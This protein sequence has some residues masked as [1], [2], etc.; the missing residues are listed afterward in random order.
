MPIAAAPVAPIAAHGLLLLLLQV[1]LLLLLALLLGRLAARFGMPAIVGELC[2]GVIAGPS[3]LAHV[4]PDFYE[5]LLPNDP[6]QFHLLDAVGQVGVMLLVGITGL[7]LDLSLLRRRAASAARV[8]IGGVV[9]PLGLG[10]LIGLVLPDSLVPDGTERS[11]FA[12]FLGVAMAVSAIPVLAKTLI[13][14]RMLHRNIGQLTLCAVVIDDVIGWLLLAVVSAM[15][16]TGLRAG[17]LGLSLAYLALTIVAAFLLRP[18]VR[19][20]LRRSS[21]LD[22]VNNR[23]GVGGQAATVTLTVVLILLAAAA[24]QAMKLEA[25]FGAFVCGMVINSCNVVQ[26]AQIAPLRNVVL[27][28]LAPVFFA[29]AGLRMDLTLLGDLTVLLTGFAV[30]ACAVVGKFVGAY[31]GAR[32]SRLTR[33]E[34]LALG[35]GM[36]ARGVIEVIIAMVGLRLGVLSPAMYTIVVLVAVVTSLMAP[37]ILRYAMARVEH[38]AE[39]ELR[40]REEVSA[41]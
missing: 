5:W 27:S 15:A 7:R 32:L 31:A 19:W 12:L 3:I 39:E 18:L 22:R 10:V 6:D 26:P 34:A 13:D 2:A 40:E 17:D 11:T 8:S 16:T 35:A 28:F 37:P 30:L 9:V 23:E 4:S 25:V 14:L 21:A 33:W 24:T 36:N 29:T 38:T 41:R 20:A 1:G